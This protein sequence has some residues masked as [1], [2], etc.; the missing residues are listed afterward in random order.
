MNTIVMTKKENLKY[1]GKKYIAVSPLKRDSCQGC[2][3]SEMYCGGARCLPQGRKDGR[4]VIF[5]LK[6]KK[7]KA[8]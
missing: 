8:T 2:V 7:E 3:F 1:E 4:D 5:V 6:T